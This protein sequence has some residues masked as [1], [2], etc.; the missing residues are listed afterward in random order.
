MSRRT[1]V[2]SFGGAVARDRA[3]RDRRRGARRHHRRGDRDRPGLASAAIAVVSLV[4]LEVGLS[5][6]RERARE[7]ARA[8]TVRRRAA[9]AAPPTAGLSQPNRMPAM[10]S[11][12]ARADRQP[13]RDPRRED[14]AAARALARAL[15]AGR[16]PAVLR[17]RDVPLG[18][19]PRGELAQDPRR[20]RRGARGPGAPAELPGHLGRPGDDDHRRPLEDLLPLRLR[21]PLG[22]QLRALPG[23]GAAVRARSRG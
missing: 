22:G 1:R 12:T 10:S 18:G 7:R 9:A 19:G 21:L 3:R 23:D 13:D 8:A 16:R 6:D 17:Q 14:A 5:E 2:L 11:T 4:F 15:V 20:A